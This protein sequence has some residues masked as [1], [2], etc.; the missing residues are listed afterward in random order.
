MAGAPTIQTGDPRDVSMPGDVLRLA[1]KVARMYHERH[2]TQTDIAAELHISQ[3]R[4]SRLL[5]RAQDVGIVVTTVAV[6]AGV[7]TDLE[8]ALERVYGLVEAVVVDVGGSEQDVLPALG[9]GAAAYLETTLIGGETVGIASW[10]GS[11]IAAVDRMRPMRGQ[12]VEAVVQLVGGVGAT[13]VQ[14]QATRL[15]GRFA[16]ATG[17]EPVFM[18]APGLLGSAAARKALMADPALANVVAHWERLTT[19]LVGIGSLEPS[20]LLRDSG[21]AL[22]EPDQD[23]LR[24]AGAVGDICQR[25]FDSDGRLVRSPVNDR[26]V[27][28]EVD[29]LRRVARRIGVAGGDRK[30]TA[31]RAA[32]R[33]GWINVLITDLDEARRLL[34]DAK[35]GPGLITSMSRGAL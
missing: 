24:E 13:R 35:A 33:G 29:Q 23:V 4:V 25:F 12:V 8:D 9:A 1:V 16:A 20:P 7:H 17:A 30:H 19:A 34:A 26:V 22:P 32:L 31:L 3:P 14:M 21:N 5:K 15:L 28:I 27:G 6:P 18:S 10:S 2:M 11:L